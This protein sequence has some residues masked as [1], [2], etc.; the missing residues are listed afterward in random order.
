MNY[1]AQARDKLEQMQKKVKILAIETSCDETAAA[2]VEDGR[3]V[4]S[5]A[6]YTQIPIHAEYGGVVPELA[7]RNH[8]EKLPYVVEAALADAKVS[9]EEIDC[10]AVTQGP[11][12]VGALLTGVSYAKALAFAANKP[13][14]PVDHI[15]GHLSAN[16]ITYPELEPPF[17]C[18]IAS[19]GHTHLVKTLDY[20]VYELLGQTR[21]DAAGEAFDKVA[22]VLGMQ[23][24]GG[25]NLERLAREGEKEK[26]SFPRSLK[27][28]DTLDF[29]FSGLKTYTIN[30]VHRMEQAEENYRRADVAAGFQKAVIETLLQ[31][32]FLA[33]ERLDMGS[34]V[35]AGGVCANEALREAAVKRGQAAKIRVYLPD[36]RY[37]TDNAAMIGAAAYYRIPN[38]CAD[39][40]LNA[41]PSLEIV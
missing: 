27:G 25:P 19:G 18:L 16:Y 1:A 20:G 30:L 37:C 26:Y 2:V 40:T 14:I 29:S 7:S 6:I 34:V 41:D 38:V 36:K 11:G 8:V 13:L 22:R 4:L 9:M 12:L 32:T 10:F 15:E 21:D 33:A 24:P 17:V 31:R 5:S 28:E 35:L 3:R 39:L 23:Y